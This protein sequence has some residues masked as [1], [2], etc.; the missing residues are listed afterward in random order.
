MRRS[1]PDTTAARPRAPCQ[2]PPQFP[3]GIRSSHRRSTRFGA[4]APYAQ[5]IEPIFIPKLQ[6]Y[7]A[8]FP[9][10]HCSID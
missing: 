2:R 4:A 5:P 9:Y 10:S 8:D 6:I 7:F 1:T 3:E